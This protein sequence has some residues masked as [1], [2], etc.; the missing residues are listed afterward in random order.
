MILKGDWLNAIRISIW[1]K[2]LLN[3]VS[4]IA[5][6][7]INQWCFF[8]AWM[9]L[10]LAEQLIV[11]HKAHWALFE[12]VLKIR[13]C[14][15]SF[16]R[17]VTHMAKDSSIFSECEDGTDAIFSIWHHQNGSSLANS[18]PGLGI[19]DFGGV[20]RVLIMVYMHTLYESMLSCV[21]LVSIFIIFRDI[22]EL[23]RQVNR[24]SR[25]SQ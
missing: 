15:F 18:Q 7:A 12:S 16:K 6:E 11:L 25:G 8:Y 23:L 4:N 2:L 9:I 1:Y 10:F 22:W 14:V 24:C 13:A 19:S 3:S 20:S 5:F 21:Q 17:V